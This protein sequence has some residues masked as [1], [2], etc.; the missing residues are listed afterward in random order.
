MPHI[1]ERKACRIAVIVFAFWALP[2]SA[3]PTDWASSL[4]SF[5]GSVSSAV[6]RVIQWTRGA[7]PSGAKQPARVP[8]RLRT[9]NDQTPETSGS[10]MDPFGKV[11]PCPN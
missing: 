11:I 3:A 8:A 6:E 4:D 7:Q 5:W 10:C 1:I 2:A 9:G